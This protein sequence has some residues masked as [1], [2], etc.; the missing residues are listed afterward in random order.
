MN[1]SDRNLSISCFQNLQ[2]KYGYERRLKAS[3]RNGTGK[4]FFSKKYPNMIPILAYLSLFFVFY[5]K[6]FEVNFHLLAQ[7]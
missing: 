4:N 2:K 5:E 6:L 3:L 7:V 1:L